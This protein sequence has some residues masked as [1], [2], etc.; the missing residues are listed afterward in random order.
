MFFKT[1]IRLRYHKKNTRFD[2][3]VSGFT[4]SGLVDR[5][6]FNFLRQYIVHTCA[7]HLPEHIRV[8]API[9]AGKTRHFSTGDDGLTAV[10]AWVK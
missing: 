3:N 8:R 2:F 10:I 4:V 7:P 9:Y 5:T 6:Q 1:K